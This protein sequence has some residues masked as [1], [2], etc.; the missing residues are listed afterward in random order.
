MRPLHSTGS[1]GAG[2]RPAYSDDV[3]G[4]SIDDGERAHTDKFTWH[5]EDVVVLTDEEVAEIKHEYEEHRE[6]PT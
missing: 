1:G 6:Q 5:P 4:N 3:S 2:P